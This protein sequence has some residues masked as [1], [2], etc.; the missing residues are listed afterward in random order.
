M[1]TSMAFTGR[2]ADERLS[3][4]LAASPLETSIASSRTIRIVICVC[5]DETDMLRSLEVIGDSTS[6]QCMTSPSN[7]CQLP[8]NGPSAVGASAGPSLVHTGF[9]RRVDE[10]MIELLDIRSGVSCKLSTG[11]L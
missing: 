1:T 10:N 2:T 4:L 3:S 5:I 11:W 9:F 6:V 8:L 7:P